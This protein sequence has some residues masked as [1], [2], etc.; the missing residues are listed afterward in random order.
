[1]SFYVT[2]TGGSLG[3]GIYD[4]IGRNGGPGKLKAQ[5]ASITPVSGW[6]TANCDFTSV[7]AGGHV[8]ESYRPSSNSLGFM[9]V[10][11]GSAKY[12][13]YAYGTLPEHLLHISQRAPA[14]P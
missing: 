1:M 7:I 6:N 10:L 11:T 5:N 2:T 13:S 4:A 8:L 14:V 3:M 12:Y 9:K